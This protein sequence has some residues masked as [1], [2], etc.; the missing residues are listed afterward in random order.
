MRKNIA[1]KLF[2]S[3]FILFLLNSFGG[4]DNSTSS[5][6]GIA[7]MEVTENTEYTGR[8]NQNEVLITVKINVKENETVSLKNIILVKNATTQPT[9]VKE[10]KIY[11]TG[12]RDTLDT[13]TLATATLLGKT[14]QLKDNNKIRLS[15]NLQPGINHLWIT[16]DIADNATEGN[17]VGVALVSIG[18]NKNKKF[19]HQPDPSHGRE[20]LLERKLIFA[21]GDFNSKFYRIPAIITAEDGSLIT[22]T[23]KRKNNMLD[24]PQDIDVVI[25]RSTDNGKTWSYPLTL[26]AGQGLGKGYGDASLIRLN[27]GKILCV[28]AGI[29]GLWQSRPDSPI[30]TYVSE[31]TDN[32]I[33][34][35]SGIDITS[36]LYG[37]DCKD[38]IRRKWMASF[39]ASGQAIQTSLGRVMMVAAVREGSDYSL[40]NYLIYSDDEGATWNVSQKAMEGG[41]EAKVV[42]LADGSILMSIRNKNKGNRYYTR[43]TDNGITWATAQLWKDLKEPGCNGDII[44]YSMEK[45]GTGKNILLHSIPFDEK[46]R[47]N[48]SVYVSYD[49]GKTWPTGKTI[50]AGP[51]AYSSL[52]VLK[53][54][55]IGAYIEEGTSAGMNMYYLNFSLEWLTQNT[56]KPD[57]R[58]TK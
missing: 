7:G 28:Y 57:L 50:C 14:S 17:K 38:P 33:T 27:N 53:D 15:G 48:V 31:S 4:C 6:K 2:L 55:T 52:T 23:D 35:T 32:G 44:R 45:N 20:I 41:D 47:K 24:L 8:G 43:S 9:D 39:C 10:I 18:Y 25:R 54:G 26:A 36:Q 49:E 37:T 16:A 19:E 58:K 42:E 11:S 56:N 34:W 30:R 1:V 5:A 13:R 51:S 29:N 21:P 12:S 3:L 46:D 40:N 22:A